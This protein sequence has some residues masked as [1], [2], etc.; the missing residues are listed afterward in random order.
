MVSDLYRKLLP[1]STRKV[2]YDS[3]LG[4]IVFFVRNF[5]V[6]A[7]SKFTF[8][9]SSLLPKTEENKAFSFIGRHGIT[10]YPDEYMLEYQKLKINVERDLTQNLPYVNHGGKKL[11]FPEFY[12]DEKV[13]KD[14]RALLIE[15]DVRS[16]HRYVKDYNDL[17]GKTL[18]DVGAAEGI[19]SLD[20]I[21]L[22]LQVI[23]FEC[24]EHWLKPLRATFAPWEHKVTFIKKY[25]GNKSEGNFITIDEFLADRSR[26][27]LFIKMDIEGAERK[28]LEGAD[29]TLRLGKNI[30]L[31]VCTYHRPGDPEYMENL[32]SEYG[33]SIEF[34]DGLLYWNKRVSKAVI[35]CKKN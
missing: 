7:K 10:S 23:I 24:E 35:R 11:Y 28:A 17:K 25:V 27:N 2:I 30:Q 33:Y 4:E 20:T 9:F 6:I 34:S 31:A 32:L 12:K 29:T 3:F 14:Y 22:T 16:A 13:I 21:E 18:L 15:R 5:Q 8:L 1:L 19:F 26:E